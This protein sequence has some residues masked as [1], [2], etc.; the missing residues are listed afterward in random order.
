MYRQLTEKPRSGFINEFQH[1]ARM[2]AEAWTR[3][4]DKSC[5]QTSLDYLSKKSRVW[6]DVQVS[7]ECREEKRR[8]EAPTVYAG[9]IGSRSLSVSHVAYIRVSGG[10]Q[11]VT[12]CQAALQD[13]AGFI[14]HAVAAPGR[15]RAESIAR[16]GRHW[17]S[18]VLNPPIM[19]CSAAYR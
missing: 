18:L 8:R 10:A 1:N 5:S 19:I 6:D 13:H 17:L 16:E 3:Q 15:W 2:F 4:P 14:R 11:A 7:W 12:G 9:T